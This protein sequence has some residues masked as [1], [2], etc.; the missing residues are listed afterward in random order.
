LMLLDLLLSLSHEESA[1]FAPPRKEV[2]CT[3]RDFLYTDDIYSLESLD[4]SP[5]YFSG[6]V[7][8]LLNEQPGDL[9]TV[10]NRPARLRSLVP[11]A[12]AS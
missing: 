5:L 3:A 6:L 12:H 7:E 4:Q 2:S 9:N 1:H 8:R 10:C 11:D